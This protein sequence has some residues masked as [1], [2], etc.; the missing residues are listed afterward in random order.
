[1]NI[2][3]NHLTETDKQ[4]WQK[5][6]RGY[7]EFYNM[8]MEQN[9]LDN[10]WSWIHNNEKE[11]YGLIARNNKNQAVGLMH[12]RAMPSPLRGSEVGFLDDLFITPEARGTDVIDL[13]YKELNDFG[14]RQGWPFIRWI[15][16]ENNYRARNVYD[17]ISQKTAWVTYQLD[18]T[19]NN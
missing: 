7:A 8:P 5:L 3:V 6:Y 1:M 17:K 14:S 15:T 10:V 18:I 4:D 11:F 2:T 12:F 9:T 16:A 13:L 19:D